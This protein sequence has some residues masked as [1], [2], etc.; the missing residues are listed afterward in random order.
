[1]NLTVPLTVVLFMALINEV[2]DQISQTDFGQSASSVYLGV[3]P[4]VFHPY[5]GVRNSVY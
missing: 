1:V 3:A 4:G 5:I 2:F